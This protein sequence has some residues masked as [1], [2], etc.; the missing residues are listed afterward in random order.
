MIMFPGFIIVNSRSNAYKKSLIETRYRTRAQNKVHYL[1][2][3]SRSWN[4]IKTL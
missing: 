2:N 4:N 3:W 1:R